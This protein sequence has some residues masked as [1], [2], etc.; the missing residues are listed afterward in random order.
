[1]SEEKEEDAPPPL[2]TAATAAAFFF[3][4]IALL[5]GGRFCAVRDAELLVLLLETRNPCFV[6]EDAISLQNER[7]K[8][9]E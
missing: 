7:R 2:L 9:R 6:R 3:G 4:I 1:V 8:Q 5:R